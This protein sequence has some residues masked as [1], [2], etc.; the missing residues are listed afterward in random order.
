MFLL[1]IE[2]MEV[3][4]GLSVRRHNR[5]RYGVLHQIYVSEASRLSLLKKPQ[6]N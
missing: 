1:G 5:E 3:G 4:Y 2:P 6:V